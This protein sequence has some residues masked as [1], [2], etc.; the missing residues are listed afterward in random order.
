VELLGMLLVDSDSVG[1]ADLKSTPRREGL[2]DDEEERIFSYCKIQHCFHCLNFTTNGH[3]TTIKHE[4]S[5]TNFT[6]AGRTIVQVV[7]CTRT[8]LNNDS[9]PSILTQCA[10]S[11]RFGHL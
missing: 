8:V 1:G 4:E 10:F 2:D 6:E 11:H 9:C 3:Q 7:W 5:K